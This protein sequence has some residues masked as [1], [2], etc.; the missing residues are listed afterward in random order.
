[1]PYL[2]LGSIYRYPRDNDPTLAEVDDFENFRHLTHTPGMPTVQLE[3]GIN[4]TAPIAAVDGPRRP[5]ILLRS[6]PWKAGTV[7]TPWH[8]DFDLD[9]GHVRY[10]GDHKIESQSP[11]GQTPGNKALLDQFTLHNATT[12]Q[13][14]ELAAPLLLF[15]SVT[16]NGQQKGYVEFCGLG[17]LERA[18]RISQ[19]DRRGHNFAN[20]VFDVALLDLRP[21]DEQL[22]WHWVQ[23]RRD[24]SVSMSESLARAPESWRRWVKAGNQA[25]PQLRRRVATRQVHTLKEQRP[26]PG[27][28]Q[29]AD[30]TTVYDYFHNR[31]HAFEHVAA[32]VTAQ[33]IRAPGTTYI[34]G[35]LTRPASDGGADF[36]GRMDAGSGVA[37]TKFVVFGQAKCVAPGRS[38]ISAEQ[39]ARVTA[40]LKRG[41]MGAY[42]T[43]DAYSPAAQIEVVEDQHPMLLISG[44]TVAQQL[45][46][47]AETSHG[48]DIKRCIDSMVEHS[49]YPVVQRR[50]EEILLW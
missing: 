9:N 22:D 8:D 28:A 7:Q 13:Q 19:R 24:R 4:P 32:A 12:R 27:S 10:F 30:L 49:P 43:T 14:R 41:W 34:D 36:I 23:A 35:W 11:V 40:R 5:V 15:R 6:S 26:L 21:E 25:L 37:V 16:R 18:E 44:L 45:R 42:V 48:G 31:K 47:I 3:R 17:V 50:P 1:M 2:K 33:I 46:N 39:V 29:A 20:Y 38:S